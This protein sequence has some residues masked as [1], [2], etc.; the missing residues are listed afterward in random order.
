[1]H[2]SGVNT[3]VF[4]QCQFGVMTLDQMGCAPVYK[5]TRL[6]VNHPVLEEKL[7]KRCQGGH[8]HV[9]LQGGALGRDG[10]PNIQLDCAMQ[11]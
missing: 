9:V 4:D 6:I 2:T 1:M 10:R 7:G 8:R 3:I 11:C 5:P